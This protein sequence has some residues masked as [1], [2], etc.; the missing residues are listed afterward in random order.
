MPP[1]GGSGG[2]SSLGFQPAQVHWSEVGRP[3]GLGG[4]FRNLRWKASFEYHS[5]WHVLPDRAT[6]QAGRPLAM[7][8]TQEAQ[9]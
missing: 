5:T 1:L 4:S 8:G 6:T 3:L 2:C 9:R 7:A